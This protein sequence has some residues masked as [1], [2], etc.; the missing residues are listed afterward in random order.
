M[1]K[2]NVNICDGCKDRLASTICALCSKDLCKNCHTDVKFSVGSRINHSDTA[3]DEWRYIPYCGKCYF[4]KLSGLKITDEFWNE[5]TG[6]LI[7]HI[8]KSVLVK[9]IQRTKKPEEDEK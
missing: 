6:N 7:E 8:K 5:V 2:E 3:F 9:E 4:K 1:K